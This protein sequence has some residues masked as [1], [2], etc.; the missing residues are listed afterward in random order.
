MNGVSQPFSGVYDGDGLYVDIAFTQ[1]SHLG[2]GNRVSKVT[3]DAPENPTD[4]RD[5]TLVRTVCRRD[6]SS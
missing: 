2:R 1:V 3:R 6:G 4:G 5:W